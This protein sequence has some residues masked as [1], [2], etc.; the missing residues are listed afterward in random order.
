MLNVCYGCGEYHADKVIDPSGPY[1]ICP[2]CGYKHS[3][4]MQ[5][6]LIV[7]GASGA[8]KSTVLPR[9]VG[10]VPGALIIDTDI[11]WMEAF[12]KPED[13]YRVYFEAWLRI[14]I[15]VG[16]SSD[17]VVLFGT[18]FGVPA[19]LENCVGRRYFSTIHYLA[20]VCSDEELANRLRSRPAWRK[21]S[22]EDFLNAHIQFNQWFKEEGSKGSP[23]ITLLDTTD[24]PVEITVEQVKGWIQQTLTQSHL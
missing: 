23:P 10:K 15:N 22:S 17:P 21:S 18:G 12:D 4:R 9:L 16:Q 3:F 2:L 13:G 24:I 11:L 5:P 6:L 14:A 8:G 1:A 7:S 19:N 20:L